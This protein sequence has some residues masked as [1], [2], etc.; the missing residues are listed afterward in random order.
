MTREEYKE[1]LKTI[2]TMV[3]TA[4]HNAQENNPDLCDRLRNKQ[5]TPDK[6]LD[7]IADEIMSKTPD[8]LFINEKL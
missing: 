5:I 6:Y 4:E 3:F 2:I 8:E 7:I 1:H